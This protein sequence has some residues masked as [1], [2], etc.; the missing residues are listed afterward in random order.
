MIK[1]ILLILFMLVSLAQ[2]SNLSYT[3]KDKLEA[4][5]SK[6]E[7]QLTKDV[8]LNV[9]LFTALSLVD[10][11]FVEEYSVH[12]ENTQQPMLTLSYRF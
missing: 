5:L 6:K 7:A 11:R 4:L 12:E 8:Y 1:N 9:N 10:D 2:A 3:E